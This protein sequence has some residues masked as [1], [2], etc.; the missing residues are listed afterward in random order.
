[1]RDKTFTAAT[2]AD[3]MSLVRDEL[4]NDAVIVSVQRAANGGGATVIASLEEAG[5]EAAPEA[6][7]PAVPPLAAILPA[8][9]ASRLDVFDTVRQALRG[10]GTPEHLTERLAHA[11]ATLAA[12]DPATALAGALKEELAFASLPSPDDDR[13]VILVGPPGAGKTMT[14]A[15]LA[16]RWT[17]AGERVGVV[18]TDNR[19]PGAAEELAAFMR[20][21]GL[22]LAVARTPAAL[23]EAV[24]ADQDKGTLFIDSAAVNPFEDRDMA[25][26]MALIAAAG[27]EPV[28]VL[29]A[30]SDALEAADM[31][32]AF[33]GAGARRMIVS[34][35]DVSRRL[36][37]LLAMLDGSPLAL[38]G[39]GDGPNVADGLKPIDA[40]RLARRVMPGA[41]HARARQPR[42]GVAS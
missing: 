30:A 17:L 42:A 9:G 31:A 38:A 5:E 4:G 27:A 36:G 40:A 23:G 11:A 14:T 35:L 3:A 8:A 12:G 19:R 34:R 33:A 7:V 13:P 21:L 16:A 6:M 29:P 39:V 10:H 28:P 41:V 26:L 25:A 15:R 18:T 20:I 1:M 2:T 37:G 32:D 22:E 24:V